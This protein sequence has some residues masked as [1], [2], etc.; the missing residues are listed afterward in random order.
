M[1]WLLNLTGNPFYPYRKL[2]IEGILT[3]AIQPKQV[4]LLAPE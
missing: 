4:K 2:E 3:T 1:G